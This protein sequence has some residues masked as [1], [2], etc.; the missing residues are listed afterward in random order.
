ML[1]LG[2]AMVSLVAVLALALGAQAAEPLALVP[3]EADFVI[4]LRRPGETVDLAMNVLR[5]QRLQA[6]PQLQEALEQVPV[7]RFLQLVR[8]AERELGKPW[9]QLVDE[10]S[11]DGIILAGKYG[12][13]PSPILLIVQGR[14]A[15]LMSRAMVLFAEVLEQELGRRDLPNDRR[16]HERGGLK[17]TQIGQAYFAVV[18]KAFLLSNRLEVF[19]YVAPLAHGQV[20]RSLARSAKWRAAQGSL[21]EA[22]LVWAWFDL[23][24]PKQ[25]KE[26]QQA[27]ELPGDAFV[28]HLLFGRYLD[29]FKRSD[30]VTAY[31][32]AD[33]THA[34][35]TIHAP[36]GWNGSGLAACAQM[37]A[38][39]KGAI[40]PPLQVPGAVYSSSFYFDPAAFLGQRGKLLTDKQR[41]AFEE[42]DK[43]SAKFLLGTRFSELVLGLGSRHRLVVAQPDRKTYGQDKPATIPSFALVLE[44]KDPDRL[45]PKLAAIFRGAALLVTFKT[46]LE[47]VE[48]E[49]GGVKLVGYRFADT[50]ANRAVQNG[51]LFN[52][53]PC[54]AQVGDQLVLCSTLSLGRLLVAELQREQAKPEAMP[55]RLFADVFSWEGLVEVL[56][57]NEE[58]L[59]VQF[60]LERVQSREA[61][62]KQAE[63]V[64]EL[65]RS[66]GRVELRWI[67]EEHHSRL[68]VE[69]KPQR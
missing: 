36:A 47:L 66:L 18:G 21:P 68:E 40:R 14:D 31:V 64:L 58:Q 11:G 10:L 28:L 15:A 24:P 67:S 62:E 2:R 51:V 63:T 65:F 44:L 29:V 38:G 32:L 53:S 30:F 8:Y 19:D 61:A 17:V 57:S 9:R 3:Q 13:Q 34:T 50:E 6:L 25:L 27:L 26:V 60:M 12:P 39:G 20:E 22:A 42:F 4:A 35:L 54:F 16:V 52:F 49:Q 48:E 43:N 23:R 55:H 7:R 56:R 45:G 37:P 46:R 1:R 5:D 59:V 69:L 41:Q 33:S